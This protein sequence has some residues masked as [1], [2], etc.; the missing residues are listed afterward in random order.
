MRAILILFDSLSKSY[1]PPYGNSWVKAPNFDALAGRTVTFDKNYV[2]SMPCIPARRELH[3]GRYNFLHRSWG[4]LEPFDDSMPEI[5]ARNGVYTHLVTDHYHYWEDGGATYHNR[6]SSYEFVRGQEGDKWK[7]EVADPAVPPHLGYATRQDWVNRSYMRRE[8]ETPQAQTF[9][10]ALEFLRR[11]HGQDKWFLQIE[12]FDPHPPFFVPDRFRQLYPEDYKGPQFDWPHYAPV[13]KG[14]SREAIEHCQKQY[15]A[16]VSACDQSLGLILDAMDR[17][18]LWQDTLLIVTTDHGFLLGEHGW[19][20]FV[21][22]PF[23]SEVATKPLFIWDPRTSKQGFRNPHVVQTHDLSATLLEFFGLARPPDMQGIPLGQTLATGSPI[24]DAALFGV[25]GG[26]V[27]CTDGRYVYMRA[28]VRPDNRPLHNYTLM[29]THMRKLFSLDELRT[30]ELAGPFR[31][32]KGAK[33]MKTA[34]S[35]FMADAH[36]FGTLL[37]DLEK[38]PGQRQPIQDRNVEERMIR[39]TVRLME[40][41][42][43]PPEQFERLGLSEFREQS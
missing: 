34:A 9:R 7:G 19:W 41:N 16:L 24:R 28:P 23:Y 10:L 36:S 33:V 6:Y 32:T 5:L 14:E 40:E 20:A 22:P 31:F 8:E 1:L 25:F 39:H 43:A 26:H 21:R 42:D 18:G 11:N 12:C 29:P 37:F 30:L 2:G 27:N 3:T 35:A 13:A 15:A 4:P 17:H 38:D